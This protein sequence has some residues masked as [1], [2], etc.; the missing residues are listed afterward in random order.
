LKPFRLARSSRTD[1]GSVTNRHPTGDG[2]AKVPEETALPLDQVTQVEYGNLGVEGY[3]LLF[4]W[5][6]R[7]DLVTGW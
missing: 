6:S 1:V 3:S 4:E 7:S 5:H 2:R